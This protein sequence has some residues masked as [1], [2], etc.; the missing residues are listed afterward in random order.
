MDGS[1]LSAK[2]K[3]E[4]RCEIESFKKVPCLAVISIGD[5]EASKIYI[6]NKKKSC[7]QVGIGFIHIKYDEN[8]SEETVIE[9]INELNNDKNVSGIIVQLPLPDKF[10]EEKIINEVSYLK[11]VD[12]LTY[13]SIGRLV[14]KDKLFIPCTAKGIIEILDYYNIDLTSKHVVIIGRSNLV[15]RPLFQELI[16]RDATCTM[17]HSKTKDLSFYTKTA[18]ILIVACGKKYLIDKTMVK[19]GSVII[20]VGIN[21]VD[22]VIYGDV[23][24]NV[25]E[26]CSYRTPVPKGV[27]PM[28][29]V[30]LL[31]NTMEAYKEQNK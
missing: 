23:N 13:S 7:K 11:D 27:G 4:L 30:M 3:D 28:T 1:L 21:R 17:C 22:G 25:D 19:E 26:I 20:D 5:D 6:N 29:V 9:K 14:S 15:S 18:D 16:N 8:I 24:P 2:I 10:N 12:G 31:K